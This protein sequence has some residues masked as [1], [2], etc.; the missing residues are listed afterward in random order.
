MLVFTAM[1]VAVGGYN[2]HHSP[3]KMRGLAV[4]VHNKAVG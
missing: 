1:L 3:Q 4:L 2:I